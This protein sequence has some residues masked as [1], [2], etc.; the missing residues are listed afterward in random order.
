[1]AGDGGSAYEGI[2]GTSMACPHVSG[3][4]ALAVSWYY[5]AE[6]KK[7]LTN[8][9]LK[10]ALLSSVTPVDPFC[11]APYFGNMGAGSLDTYQLLLAVKKV[12]MIPDV[13]V[14]RGGEVTVNLSEY[15]YKTDV[16]T[17]SVAAQGIVEVSL[18]DS[19]LTIKG[20]SKGKT[21]IR[22]TDGN[23]SV[24]TINVTVK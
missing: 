24:R 15:L 9:M 23:Q 8:E 7:G 2:N 3:A 4:C 11:D 1:M 12:A 17:Y 21:V 20:V 5:G 13:T 22:I 19:V 18:K 6:K 10:E 16:L 14:S